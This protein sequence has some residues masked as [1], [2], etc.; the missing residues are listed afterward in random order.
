MYYQKEKNAKIHELYNIT[1]MFE[2]AI[3]HAYN[4]VGVK[5]VGLQF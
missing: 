1:Y 4:F 2:F 5:K 3:Y